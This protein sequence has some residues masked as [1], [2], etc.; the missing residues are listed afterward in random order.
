MLA[1]LFPLWVEMLGW[2][3]SCF[4]SCSA[5]AQLVPNN[6]ASVLFALALCIALA[7]VALALFLVY[8]LATR[9][10]WR[11]LIVL[12]FFLLGG[13]FDVT[14]VNAL[15]PYGQATVPLHPETDLLFEH[16]VG[17][18]QFSGRWPS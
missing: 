8:C 12:L 16:R 5:S 10:P 1:L 9:Q 18:G 13:L 4:D 3:F 15:V 6:V 7:A 2:V 14:A 17:T 11:A